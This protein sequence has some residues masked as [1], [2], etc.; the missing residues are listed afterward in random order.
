MSSGKH[1]LQLEKNKPLPHPRISITSFWMI[2]MLIYSGFYDPLHS[3]TVPEYIIMVRQL[4]KHLKKITRDCHKL[5]KK[6]TL[7]FPIPSEECRTPMKLWYHG[8]LGFL[9]HTFK[10]R[11]IRI[12]GWCIP[13]VSN[14]FVT[15]FRSS[16]NGTLSGLGMHAKN[17]RPDSRDTNFINTTNNYF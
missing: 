11:S 12:T 7:M 8:H 16:I 15:R 10:S 13:G 6:T 1:P 4:M 2:A 9:S 3:G 14:S 17:V 5:C